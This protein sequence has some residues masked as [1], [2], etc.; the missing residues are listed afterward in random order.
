[1]RPP[2]NKRTT[3]KSPP[4]SSRTTANTNITLAPRTKRLTF[5]LALL[6]GDD[7]VS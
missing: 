1:L 6:S 5:A 7:G 2:P 4:T 3:T